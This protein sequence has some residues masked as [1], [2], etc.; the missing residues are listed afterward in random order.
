MNRIEFL[1]SCACGLCSCAAAGVVAP[2]DAAAAETAPAESP[3]LGFAQRR[4]AKLLEILSGRM[5]PKALNEILHDL[6]SYCSTTGKQ[7]KYRG[8]FEGFCK[9]V[10]EQ[11]NEDISFD[12]EKGVI[13]MTS[14]GRTDC[15]CALHSRQAHTPEV[16]CN[17]S[18]GWQQRTWET[19]L[20]KPVKVELAESVLRGGK[21]CVFKIYL[22]TRESKEI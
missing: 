13:T 19:V 14:P 8:D 11:G 18:L 10:R 1:K 12:H 4:Y 22:D 6:G 16:V 5:E 17:C 21:R 3:R 7:Q 20:G 9:Y 15:F 2:V